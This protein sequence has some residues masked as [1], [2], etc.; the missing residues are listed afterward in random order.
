[1]HCNVCKNSTKSSHK[2]ITLVLA[3]TAITSR[4]VDQLDS[5]GGRLS[6]AEQSLKNI[7]E[8]RVSPVPTSTQ[9][10][11]STGKRWLKRITEG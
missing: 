7:Q 1:M 5:N 3:A 9:P 4:S 8:G 2:H 6:V 10:P 11:L